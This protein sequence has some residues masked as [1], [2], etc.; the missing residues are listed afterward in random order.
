MTE[1]LPFQARTLPEGDVAR[2]RAGQLPAAPDKA[3]AAVAVS[4]GENLDAAGKCLWIEA[5]RVLCAFAVVVLHTAAQAQPEYVEAGAN[6]WIANIANA[7][8]RFAVPV[9]VMISGALLLD[10]GRSD[11]AAQFYRKR[12]T[13]LLPPFAV[14]TILYLILR[15]HQVPGKALTVRHLGWCFLTGQVYFHLWYLFILPGL[16][17]VTPFIR[18][19]LQKARPKEVLWLV[20]LIYAAAFAHEVVDSFFLQ[21]ERTIFTM[22][23]PYLSYY[24]LGW[25]IVYRSHHHVSRLVLASVAAACVSAIALSVG[26]VTR[27]YP[28]G[29]DRFPYRPFCPAVLALSAAVFMS[30]KN[31]AGSSAI[32]GRLLRHARFLGPATFGIYLVHPMFLYFA[33]LTG[34]YR[35]LHGYPLAFIPIV[36]I[37]AFGLSLA[38]VLLVRKIPYVRTAV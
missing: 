19:F 12:L 18:T 17:L 11:T 23:I 3:H 25:W 26:L 33:S 21:N 22:F 37:V 5:L 8:A 16:Y 10:L 35:L 14:W 29:P 28:L 20:V 9:F 31:L 6:W 1:N 7:A 4:I 2:D 34:F 36:S 15:Y 13:R 24:I 27:E 38:T 32:T 30:F